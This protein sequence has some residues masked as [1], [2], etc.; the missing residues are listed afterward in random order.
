MLAALQEDDNHG[1]NLMDAAR[2]LAGGLS[3]LLNAV[4]PERK[5]VCS[6]LFEINLPVNYSNKLIENLI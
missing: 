3:D 2:R 5:E 4:Q 1:T 6:P